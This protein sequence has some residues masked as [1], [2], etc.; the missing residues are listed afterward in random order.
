MANI[1]NWP[2]RQ[3]PVESGEVQFQ[4]LYGYRRL[5]WFSRHEN[6][7][8]TE[9]KTNKLVQ[10]LAGASFDCE[11]KQERAELSLSAQGDATGLGLARGRWGS[12]N[13]PTLGAACPVYRCVFIDFGGRRHNAAV[14]E[15]NDRLSVMPQSRDS[16]PDRAVTWTCTRR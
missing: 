16:R 9:I 5:D 13:D 3:P 1:P 4:T 11:Y 6:G 7:F 12:M 14:S 10:A 2:K 8:S 15:A